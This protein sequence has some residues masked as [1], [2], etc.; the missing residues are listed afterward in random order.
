MVATWPPGRLGEVKFKGPKR[1]AEDALTVVVVCSVIVPAL[2]PPYKSTNSVTPL[3]KA[4]VGMGWL[5]KAAS[6]A[7]IDVP[8]YNKWFPSFTTV[9]LPWANALMQ[10]AAIANVRANRTRRFFIDLSGFLTRHEAVI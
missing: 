10:E 2:V 9:I 6:A 5:A 1:P 7:L 3:G 8:K 4:V